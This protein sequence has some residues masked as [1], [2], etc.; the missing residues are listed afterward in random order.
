MAYKI[1]R[2]YSIPYIHVYSNF[3]D[4]QESKNL[5]YF[6]LQKEF[7]KKKI[8]YSDVL[9]RNMK[10]LGNQSY[11]IIENFDYLQKKWVQENISS[12]IDNFNNNEIL[13]NQIAKIEPDI[14]FFQN[15]PSINLKKLRKNFKFIKKIIQ[16]N[17]FY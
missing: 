10:K 4:K 17:F 12:K 9:S 1:L 15:L 7:F 14:I 5:N 6:E 16:N 11:E 2:I 3:L 8:S 13:E